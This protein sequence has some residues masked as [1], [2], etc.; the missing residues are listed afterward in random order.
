MLTRATPGYD[1]KEGDA[2]DMPEQYERAMNSLQTFTSG[3]SLFSVLPAINRGREE[4]RK[5]R[6]M[7]LY[8]V[9]QILDTYESYVDS[10][11]III[12]SE[13]FI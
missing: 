2:E 9:S 10:A 5:S 12:S 6:L 11:S 3:S 4:E 1:S 7:L 13:T 8:H